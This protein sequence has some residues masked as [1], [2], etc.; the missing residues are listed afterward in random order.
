VEGAGVN[1]GMMYEADLK[2]CDCGGKPV[3]IHHYIH[4]TPNRMHYFVACPFCKE[5]T[6]DRKTIAEAV[7]DWNAGVRIYRKTRE[8]K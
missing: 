4:G 2:P 3:I 6:R 5:M 1:T 8:E 7:E